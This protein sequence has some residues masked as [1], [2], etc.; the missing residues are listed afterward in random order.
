VKE[1]KSDKP[2]KGD[3]LIPVVIVQFHSMMD[4]WVDKETY[5]MEGKFI[6]LLRYLGVS[7]RSVKKVH[8]L[9]KL[10]SS[11]PTQEWEG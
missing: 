7:I 6:G 3:E 1:Y 10:A 11:F 2:K 9:R 8:H 5:D 4:F